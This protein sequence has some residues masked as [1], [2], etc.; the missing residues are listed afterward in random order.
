MGGR[1]TAG[2]AISLPRT[3]PYDP[4]WARSFLDCFGRDANIHES[5]QLA[6][7]F[8]QRKVYLTEYMTGSV[9]RGI[10][11]DPLASVLMTSDPRYGAEMTQGPN[12]Y[13]Y[14]ANDPIGLVDTSG[15]VC[16][17]PE[18]QTKTLQS[19]EP[20]LTFEAATLS[21]AY[22]PNTTPTGLIFHV[23]ILNWYNCEQDVACR[24]GRWIAIGEKR[25]TMRPGGWL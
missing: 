15:L 7:G 10:S 16:H 23:K 12:L 22:E 11:R 18:G 5:S 21:N 14:V 13:E 9:K 3:L 17:C 1:Q 20:R 6:C 24:G 2:N 19:V 8:I 4:I 25:C